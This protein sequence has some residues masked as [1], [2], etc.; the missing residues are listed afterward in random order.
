MHATFQLLLSSPPQV[1]SVDDGVLALLGHAAADFVA[2]RIDLPGCI[3]AHDD[4]IAALL[5]ASAGEAGGGVVNLRLRQADGRIR[6][7][8]GEYQRTAG[9]AG[10]AMTLHLCLQDARSLPRTLDDAALTANFRTMMDNAGDYIYFKDRNHVFTGASQTLVSLCEPAEHWTDLLGQ[11]DYDVFAEAFADS[12]YR[13]EK[14]VFAGQAVAH[15]LQET[16]GKDGRRGWVDNR[17]YPIRD[18]SGEIIGLY[19]IA[20][21]VTEQVRAQRAV[22]DSEQ[23][24]RSLYAAMIEGM[25]LH[26][27]VLD[28][29]GRPA[30]YRILDANPA[31]ES[32]TGLKRSAIVGRLATEA[33]GV[34]RAPFLDLFAEVALSGQTRVFDL[35]FDPLGKHFLI[36]VFCPQQNQFVTVFEDITAAKR[37][38]EDLRASDR[39]FRQLLEH[40]PSIAVQ[41]YDTDRRVIFWNQASEQLYGW[42]ADEAMGRSLDEL[43]IPPAM[44]DEVARMTQAWMA[45][46]PA[47]PAGELL[48]Q[49]KDGSPVPVFSSHALQMGSNGPEMF[50]LDIDLSARK[51]AEAELQRHRDQ[52]EALVQERTQALARALDAA[53]AAT[54]AKSAFLANMSHEIRTPMNAI[55]GLTALIQRR[56]D[57]AVLNAQLDRIAGAG[58]HL[59]GMIDDIL[60]LSKIEAGK[61]AQD[62]MPLRIEAIVG[63]VVSMLYERARE[64]QLELVSEVQAT[65]R[66]LVGDATRLQQAL[67]NY[68]SNAIKFTDIGRVAIGVSVLREDAQQAW[69]RF[70]VSDT[71]IGVTADVLGRLFGSFE[72]ADNSTTRRYGGTGLGLAITR[73]IAQLMGG[74]AGA[75]STPGRGSR[76]WFTARLDKREPARDT[77]KPVGDGLDAGAE[78]ALRRDHLGTHVL[79]AEDEPINREITLLMLEDVGLAV[80][81][82]RDGVEAV[83]MAARRG[84][85]LILMDMQMPRMDGLDAT[86]RIRELPRHGRTPI[87]AMTANVF[88]EDKARCLQ[89]GMSGFIGKPVAPRELYG[90]I[91]RALAPPA[92][93]TESADGT[94]A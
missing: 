60:D 89:A 2:G 11:T 90:Q 80:D 22:R 48:L 61:L 4:D 73:R 28:A 13:L 39:R 74:E 51:R 5:F 16:L 43:I 41:G 20:R 36:S 83:E 45:G 84:Y 71:G 34:D 93:G 44:R 66:G 47:I 68:V 67:L 1:L 59:L 50:C 94:Q 77:A 37:L 14:Q 12:Y 24:Y 70:E 21:D 10:A 7:V 17:K 56:S 55:L 9:E 64:K 87:L 19:G 92:D 29:E 52:L 26:E 23:R 32:H 15:E 31:Y 78:H 35:Y 76:F 25:A 30:D 91:L 75:E 58:R 65:P 3:H 54:Q 38:E 40:T 6:C 8:R 88:S 49:H 46:G 69:L 81:L 33:Y 72:Q 62:T 63:D 85:G 82:A 79:V 18:T 42:R 57:D 53:H 86:R 27:L